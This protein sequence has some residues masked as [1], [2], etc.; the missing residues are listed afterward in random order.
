LFG[1]NRDNERIKRTLTSGRTLL[2]L[3]VYASNDEPLR[4]LMS[5]FSKNDGKSS[6]F[7]PSLLN[8]ILDPAI[9]V[10]TKT[11]HLNG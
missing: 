9:Q 3:P 7:K 1:E 10:I 5:V 4:V 8:N 6:W 11:V 2:L